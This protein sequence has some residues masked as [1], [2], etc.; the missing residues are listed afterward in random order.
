MAAQWRGKD[1]LIIT[2]NTDFLTANTFNEAVLGKGEVSDLEMDTHSCLD[3]S[4]LAMFEDSAVAAETRSRLDEES[5]STLLTALTE[6]LDSVDDE[7]LSPFDTLPD[8]G[9]FSDQRLRDNSPLRRLLS[10]TGSPPEKE[11]LFRSIK[12]PSSSSSPSS[13]VGKVETVIPDRP[14][15]AGLTPR[16]QG[17]STST[18]RSDGEEEEGGKVHI[19]SPP[20]GFNQDSGEL[21]LDRSQVR[22]LNSVEKDHGYSC[23]VSLV[24]L[25]KLMHPYCLRVCLDEE[26]KDWV[27]TSRQEASSLGERS[28]DQSVP[29]EG[30]VEVYEAWFGR[31]RRGN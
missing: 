3:P 13:S 24:D 5:E 7:T 23:T 28:A 10:L 30:E 11:A 29:L 14:W 6:I 18:Q 2:G 27:S 25:V 17:S 1:A 9:L 19:H 8:T 15:R 22:A 16:A 20:H 4:I 12:T 21:S 31:E 26:G